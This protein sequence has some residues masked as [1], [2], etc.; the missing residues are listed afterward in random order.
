MRQLST[1]S[2]AALKKRFRQ[3]Y[4]CTWMEDRY[5]KETAQ[6]QAVWRQ[7]GN[8]I[9][10]PMESLMPDLSKITKAERIKE[11]ILMQVWLPGIKALLDTNSYF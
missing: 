11:M 7:G 5:S 1:G 3:I 8:A 4:L 9:K 6:R 10:D 2:A